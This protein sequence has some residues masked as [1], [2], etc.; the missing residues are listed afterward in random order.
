ML[1]LLGNQKILYKLKDIL[2]HI[3]LPTRKEVEHFLGLFEFY[4][5]VHC[6]D[7]YQVIWKVVSFE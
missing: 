7:I 2:L 3:A 1:V 4:I 5:C 6:S